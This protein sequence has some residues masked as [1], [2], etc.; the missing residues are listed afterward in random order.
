M[1]GDPRSDDWKRGEAKAD[2]WEQYDADT[3]A[4]AIEVARENFGRATSARLSEYARG[5][6]ARLTVI[7]AS[8]QQ[9]ADPD[10]R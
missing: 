1:T 6:L 2:R 5:Y 7:L 8:K 9:E 3:V 4:L 10:G